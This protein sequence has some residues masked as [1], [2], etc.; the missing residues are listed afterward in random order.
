MTVG[1]TELALALDDMD[2]NQ[3]GVRF[4]RMALQLIR[5]AWPEIVCSEPGKDLGID[6]RVPTSLAADGVGR[7]FACSITPTYAKILADARKIRANYPS[8]K[9]MI[10]ATPAGVSNQRAEGWIQELEKELGLE[11]VILSREDLVSRLLEPASAPARQLLL[12][13]AASRTPEFADLCAEVA[14]ATREN[15]DIWFAHRRLGSHPSL[16]LR[17]SI[18]GEDGKVTEQIEQQQILE[19]LE[20]HR[21][22]LLEAPPGSGK[23]TTLVQMARSLADHDVLPILMHLPEWASSRQAGLADF[24]VA[25][26]GPFQARA[27]QAAQVLQVLQ[28]RPTVVLLNGWNELSSAGL[29]LIEQRLQAEERKLPDTGFLVATRGHRFRPPLEGLSRITIQK[30]NRVERRSYLT[31]ALGAAGDALADEID[32][33]PALNDLTRT[34]FI[35]HEVM[36]LKRAGQALPA[37]KMGILEQVT[38]LFEKSP[39]H[40]NWLVRAPLHGM[41]S[42]YLSAL[43][44]EM[45]QR[46]DTLITEASARVICSQVSERLVQ[47]RQMKQ[48]AAPS[49]ILGALTDHHVLERTIQATGNLQFEH[50]QFQEFYA[51]HTLGN[52]LERAAEAAELVPAYQ[53]DFINWPAWEESLRMLAEKIAGDG[54]AVPLGAGVKA[55]LLVGMCAEV[56]LY[57]AATLARLCAVALPQD[58][59]TALVDRLRRWYAVADEAHQQ[60]ALAAIFET[61]FPEFADLVT[62]LLTS[63]DHQTRLRTYRNAR[64]L[65]LSIL[66]GEWQAI[67]SNWTTTLRSDF[68]S[69][70]TIHGGRT[71]IA[72]YF[73]L[74]DPDVEVRKASIRYMGWMRDDGRLVRAIDALPA[75]ERESALLQIHTDEVP[76]ALLAEVVHA[77]EQRLAAETDHVRRVQMILSGRELGL[78]GIADA[79]KEELRSGG[80][81]GFNHMN[82]RSLAEALTFI[83][84]TDGGWVSAWVASQVAVSALPYRLWST[85]LTTVPDEVQQ[86]LLTS[87]M[88]TE[89]G[90]QQADAISV[91][92]SVIGVPRMEQAFTTYCDVKAQTER[93]NVPHG[94]V[95]YAIIRQLE[96]LFRETPSIVSVASMASHFDQ[97]LSEAT[98]RGI[99]SLLG[100]GIPT[101]NE[102]EQ[103]LDLRPELPKEL[104]ERLRQYLKQAVTF[105]CELEDSYGRLIADLSSTL[106]RVG[107]PEDL[108]DLTRLLHADVARWTA[109][110]AAQASGK[111]VQL[112][113]WQQVHVRAL[114]TLDAPDADEV[115]IALLNV[116]QYV[117]YAARA[118][119]ELA[120]IEPEIP[121][122]FLR[123]SF[124]LVWVA[125]EGKRAARFEE[126]KRQKYAAAIR[127][128]LEQRLAQ[129]RATS[130]PEEHARFLYELAA[131][132]AILDGAA[133]SPLICD[134]AAV[135]DRWGGWHR[136]EALRQVL[137]SGGTV[138]F[139]TAHAILESVLAQM[140]PQRY[141]QDDQGRGLVTSLLCLLPYTDQPERGIAR[142][143][144]VLD[145]GRLYGYHLRGLV[146]ALG[147]SRAPGA[148]ALLTEFAGPG[149]STFSSVATEWI[150]AVGNLGGRDGATTLLAFIESGCT[151]Q[152]RALP[153]DHHLFELAANRIATLAQTDD[154]LQSKI[155]ALVN[156][157][158]PPER[159]FVII[160]TVAALSSLDAMLTTLNLAIE[161]RSHRWPYFVLEEAFQELCL[162][163]RRT[164]P[165]SNSYTLEPT[166]AVELRR[167]LLEIA[168]AG[169]RRSRN[170]F[171]LLG[172]IDVWR[173]EHGKPTREPRHPAIESGV[174]WPALELMNSLPS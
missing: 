16:T 167:R 42:S 151:A 74:Y 138:P 51:A 152:N 56:D 146:T 114:L 94:D 157:P 14:L 36:K 111:R 90:H 115:L 98:L 64:E 79:L 88:T 28:Q 109:I 107:S 27:L 122:P 140:T 95:R 47:A 170:A 100:R 50:Q 66:G 20:Q 126:G 46:G 52:A 43:A 123:E 5:Q 144:Q 6:A 105:A 17:F 65:H 21:H 150:E 26:S 99:T 160:K 58:A 110:R 118:L 141:F 87:I 135:A 120:Q 82:N 49:D 78:P 153:H 44:E 169:D 119:L 131:I 127:S 18:V 12:G 92:A 137:F 68:V 129:V 62:P 149:T 172:Q 101:G 35:L 124:R 37:T 165:D 173:L 125:R 136:A 24:L 174:Q 67:V 142:I 143:R 1:R 45:T 133:S 57:F 30:L 139:E 61:G 70:L 73:A 104:C 69:E 4:Q 106:S 85:L 80:V 11:L 33:S 145:E 3:D 55:K 19:L 108:I 117:L 130:R 29:E 158:G 72:E 93:A 10:F 159:D 7:A 38:S 32:R 83:K 128:C 2:E 9:L 132:L 63:E 48:P 40:G 112:T 22:I 163:K 86:D 76:P 75:S 41:A 154:K 31:E 147:H 162:I 121:N 168:T 15:V 166:P 81:E 113:G 54:A 77:H 91:L 134:C 59:R 71:D 25:H 89:L 161:D 97:P 156:V 96:Q 102:R 116:D 39:E 60:L 34:P 155:L 148:L 13:F 53:R 84:E 171:S 103:P 164:P 8:L 23:T